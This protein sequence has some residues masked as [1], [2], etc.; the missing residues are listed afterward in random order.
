METEDRTPIIKTLTDNLVN[1]MLLAFGLGNRALNW[2]ALRHVMGVPAS[3]FVHYIDQFDQL[4][5]KDGLPA[6]SRWIASQFFRSVNVRGRQT[7]PES[8]PVL[9]AS[10][11]P[12]ALD[13]VSI[14]GSLPRNDIQIF[15]SS[16]PFFRNIPA[17]QGRCIFVENPKSVEERMSTIL[18]GIEHLKQGGMVVIFPT[19]LV[20]PEPA[21]REG[22]KETM[23]KWSRSLELMLRKVPQTRLALTVTS[24][25]LMEKY[26]RHP[27]TLMQK[28]AWRRQRM[29]EYLQ[30][31]HLLLSKKVL[32]LDTHISF[33]QPIT[34]EQLSTGNGSGRMID[35]II[36]R[37]QALFD[38]HMN[39]RANGF[40][41]SEK[42]FT[43]ETA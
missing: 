14:L 11:H 12:G 35:E 16:S 37:E 30:V 5:F 28:Q 8:G 15:T 24:D 17:A 39:A 29:A 22:S 25:V 13:S 20:D 19:G 4:I 33:S 43:S 1:E 41:A 27:L 32:P 18:Q 10:N 9:V 38:E 23:Q 3:R 7:L 31:I 26:S 36:R 2:Q 6:A 40:T 21:F 42:L 34:A